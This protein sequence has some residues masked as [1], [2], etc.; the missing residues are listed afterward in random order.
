MEYQAARLRHEHESSRLDKLAAMEPPLALHE[1]HDDIV[2]AMSERDRKA[3]HDFQLWGVG[4]DHSLAS[5][6]LMRITIGPTAGLHDFDDGLVRGEGGFPIERLCSTLAE[7]HSVALEVA[8]HVRNLTR[9]GKQARRSSPSS[10]GKDASRNT[11]QG[12]GPADN[13]E[14]T[15]G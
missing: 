3:L 15:Q 12:H 4:R 7:G 5:A 6:A 1:A 10:G 14:A 9:L 2:D 8:Q 13:A 11:P